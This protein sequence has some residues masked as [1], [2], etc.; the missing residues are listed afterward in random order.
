VASFT[1]EPLSPEGTRLLVQP[2]TGDRIRFDAS[3]S[4]DPDGRITKYD[5]DWTSDGTCDHSTTNPVTEY[6]F[7]TAGSHRVTLRVTDDQGAT[8]TTT[9]TVW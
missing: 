8:A 3:G 7:P 2:R 1:W 9:Q 6:R 4:R 5:W